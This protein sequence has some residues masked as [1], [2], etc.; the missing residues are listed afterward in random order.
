[1]RRAA[2]RFRPTLE[3]LERRD[4]MAGG[5]QAMLANGYLYVQ[6]AQAHDFI[7]V[8]ESAG[9]VSVSVNGSPVPISTDRGGAWSVAAGAIRDVAVYSYGGAAVIDLEQS[10]ATPLTVGAVV[11]AYGGQNMV[12]GGAGDNVLYGIGGGNTLEGGGGT[13]YLIDASPLAP[14]DT[15]IGGSGFNWYYRPI[16]VGSPFA[17]GAQVA[18]IQQGQSPTCQTLAALAEAA[19]QGYNFG[20]DITYT[21][22]NLYQV[23]LHD[24]SAAQT[25]YFDGYRSDNDPVIRGGSTDFWQV[26]E[27]RARLQELGIN[28]YLNY[29]QAQWDQLNAQTSGR[30]YSV[31]SALTA[32][33]GQTSFYHTIDQASPAGLAASLA[34]GADLVATSSGTG[35]SIGPDGIIG[36]HAYSVLAVYWQDSVWKV[37]LYNPWGVDSVDGRTLDAQADGA[38]ASNDGY[39]TLTWA[40]FVDPADFHGYSQAGA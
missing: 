39:I 31:D 3:T 8:A 13:N 37:E 20:Q 25:V 30:L 32:F 16:A 7:G 12:I 14:A 27:V 34:H 26:L 28:P 36:D 17:G 19:S 22:N 2:I 24:G 4:L 40:Q 6:D 21:G 5:L 23:Q 1:M 9:Q 11:Y 35:S 18:D 38:P 33:T 15:L 29:T 10:Q